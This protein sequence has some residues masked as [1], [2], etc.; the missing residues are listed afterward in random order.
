MADIKIEKK[1]GS[2]W[3][4]WALIA[5]L[6]LGALIWFL[7]A[8]NDNDPPVRAAQTTAVDQSAMADSQTPGAMAAPTGADA[9]PITELATITDSSDG[10]LV[11]RDVKL[12]NVPVGDVPGDASFWI[13]GADGK[14]VYVVLHEVATPNTAMEGRV[15][16][17]KGDKVDVVGTL[18]AASEGAPAGAA[19]GSKTDPLPTG[20]T[21]YIYAQSAKVVS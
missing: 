18:H 5:L 13:N 17:D 7:V 16:V 4:L 9:G 15:N 8:R 12:S 1:G 6:I 3:W 21:Q 2:L 14:H 19:V 20:I 10:S 11:G